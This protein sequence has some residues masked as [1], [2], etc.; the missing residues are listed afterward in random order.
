MSTRFGI[1]GLGRIGRCLFRVAEARPELELLAT[2]DIAA[3]A[4]LAALLR[5]DSVHGRFPGPLAALGED[6]FQ[7]GTR[8]VALHH[9]A[10]PA[11][12]PWPAE[13]EMVIE[14]TGRATRRELAARHLREP[15]G[16]SKVIISAVSDDADVMLCLGVNENDYRPDQHHVISNASCTTNCLA[17]LLKV[18]HRSFGVERAL[19]N[20]VHSYTAN[21]NLVDAMHD[22]PRRGRAAAINIVPTYSAAPAACEKLLPELRGRLAG[23]A[24]RVPTPDVA[25][26][27]LVVEVSRAAEAEAVNDAFRAA[28]AGDLHGLLATSDEM[29]VSSDHIGDPHSAIV[30]TSLTQQVASRLLR[31][32]AWYDNEWGYSHRLAD[33]LAFLG[34]KK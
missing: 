10:D 33:L 11:A 26:L 12:I 7:V 24:I 25:L 28:A 15:E 8:T 16:P 9:H 27:D 17:L 32:M 18:V 20:E 22:D 1:N 29:L 6:A 5:R 30:D 2:N 3:G 34:G 13:V 4:R 21:Q 23:Q 19:M 14:A 31:V